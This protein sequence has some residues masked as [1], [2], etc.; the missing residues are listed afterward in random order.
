MRIRA[1]LVN[2]LSNAT[3]VP[4][5]NVAGNRSWTAS[6]APVSVVEAYC[7]ALF[8]RLSFSECQGSQKFTSATTSGCFLSTTNKLEPRPCA[9]LCS[10]RR[11][12]GKQH[13]AVSW[14]AW[15]I[16]QNK[17]RSLAVSG[18]FQPWTLWPVRWHNKINFLTSCQC[19]PSCLCLPP[20]KLSEDWKSVSWH[21]PSSW[22]TNSSYACNHSIVNRSCS[23]NVSQ[24]HWS[25]PKP[26]FL[27]WVAV[28][29]IRSR[30]QIFEAWPVTRSHAAIWQ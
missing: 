23:T 4:K 11:V 3:A 27:F 8:I 13:D 5:Q 25:A 21:R 10:R 17:A 1:R 30:R 19:W 24:L 12:Q 16:T 6:E 7:W 2:L 15:S 26:S 28:E 20:R 9:M 18:S 29:M 14:V 22:K